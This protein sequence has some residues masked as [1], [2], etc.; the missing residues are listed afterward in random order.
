MA[1]LFHNFLTGFPCIHVICSQVYKMS[2]N[3]NNIKITANVQF[4]HL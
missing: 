3:F 4:P 1:S 2:V